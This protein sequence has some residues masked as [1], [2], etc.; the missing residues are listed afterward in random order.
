MSQASK[1][2]AV[3]CT[4]CGKAFGYVRDGAL[5]VYQRH[6]G[7][8]HGARITPALLEEWLSAEFEWYSKG[9]DVYHNC[10]P[11]GQR[12]SAEYM[13]D[14]VWRCERCGKEWD[15]MKRERE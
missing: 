2:R 13:S 6:N 10:A 15:T 14:G 11:Y 8:W 3:L 12:K 9:R 7:Q 4:I 5:W 1:G